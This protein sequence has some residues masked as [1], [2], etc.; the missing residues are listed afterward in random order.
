MDIRA[1]RISVEQDGVL[2]ML[3]K[4]L[5]KFHDQDRILRRQADGGQQPH[6]EVD[7]VHFPGQQRPHQCADHPQRH[8]QQHR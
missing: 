2:A 1:D 3:I 4:P 5:G 7:I 6:L 8:D